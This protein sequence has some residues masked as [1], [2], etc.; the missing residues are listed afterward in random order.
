MSNIPMKDLMQKIT[1]A[2][3]K[4]ENALVEHYQDGRSGIG[5]DFSAA[6]REAVLLLRPLLQGDVPRWSF[7]VLTRA[8]ELAINIQRRDGGAIVGVGESLLSAIKRL[9]AAMKEVATI[10]DGSARV[11]TQSLETVTELEHQRVSPAQIAKMVGCSLDEYQGMSPEEK[12]KPRTRQVIVP[13]TSG[14]HGFPTEQPRTGC[15]GD[16]MAQLE[17]DQAHVDEPCGPLLAEVVSVNRGGY[18]PIEATVMTRPPMAN[19]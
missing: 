14:G 15:L 6:I 8:Q 11:E 9:A 17:H 18:S 19:K 10:G 7:S 13:P 1:A 2:G 5:D 16:W 3:Q 12:Q 4:L